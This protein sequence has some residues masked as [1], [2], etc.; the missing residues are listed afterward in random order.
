VSVP[1]DWSEL[2]NVKAANQYT[3]Q[4]LMQLISR[5]RADPWA[6]IGRIRQSLPKLK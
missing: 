6:A 1:I 5:R 2:G 4:N 3:V